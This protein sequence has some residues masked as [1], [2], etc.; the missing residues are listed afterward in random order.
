MMKRAAVK[1]TFNP[2][3]PCTHLVGACANTVG[4]VP[5]EC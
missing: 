2:T 1:T 4:G 5:H 3:Y